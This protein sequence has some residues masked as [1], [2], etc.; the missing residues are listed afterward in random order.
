MVGPLMSLHTWPLHSFRCVVGPVKYCDTL[1]GH[2]AHSLT[3]NYN[4][5]TKV[6]FENLIEKTY[7]YKQKRFK[8][9][10]IT[11]TYS[12]LLIV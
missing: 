12:V 10:V 4:K 3:L 7:N 1:I 6:K 5:Q 11:C 8:R 9:K 2:S